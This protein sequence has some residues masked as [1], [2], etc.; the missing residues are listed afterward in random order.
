MS[1][2]TIPLAEAPQPPRSKKLRLWPAIPLVVLMLAAKLAQPL[3]LQQAA[4]NITVFMVIVFGPVICCLILLLWWLFFTRAPWSD[5]LIGLAG[6]AVGCVIAWYVAD[7]S[8][9]GQASIFYVLPDAALAFTVAFLILSRWGVRLGTVS[10][11]VAGALALGYWDTVLFDGMWGNFKATMH[12]RWEKTAEEEFLAEQAM[13]SRPRGG[14][15]R[16]AAGEGPVVTVSRAEARQLGAGGR[17]RCRLEG[18]R[19]ETNLEAQGRP[20]LVVVQRRRRSD[21]HSRA[22]RRKRRR[23]LLRR[24]DR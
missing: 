7:P 24:Q 1:V 16:R 20:G 11:L 19:S 21:L 8:I 17:A 2:E 3:F 15:K 10:A 13:P 18:P 22:A 9:H 6:A 12:W 14:G 4:P 23:R 5:R